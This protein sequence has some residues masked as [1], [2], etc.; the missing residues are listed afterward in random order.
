MHSVYRTPP[1]EARAAPHFH[2]SAAESSTAE[3]RGVHSAQRPEECKLHFQLGL[4]NCP[5]H[6]NVCS[7][8]TLLLQAYLL[9]KYNSLMYLKI[10]FSVSLQSISL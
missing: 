10:S 2:T 1:R 6:L 4:C 8:L 5:S 9:C 7:V 3:L